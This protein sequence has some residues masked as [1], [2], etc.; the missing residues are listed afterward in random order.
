MPL[1]DRRSATYLFLRGDTLLCPPADKVWQL[2]PWILFNGLPGDLQPA[3]QQEA[4]HALLVSRS[5]I[6]CA[7]AMSTFPQWMAAAAQAFSAWL[8]S[9]VT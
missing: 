8:E 5:Y 6:R 3:F 7:K 1:A 2:P 4:P 9:W